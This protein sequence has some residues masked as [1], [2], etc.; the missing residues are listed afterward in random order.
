[1]SF[2]SDSSLISRDSSLSS[3]VAGQE[4]EPF[5][6]GEVSLGL[7]GSSSN[8]DSRAIVL[9]GVRMK[10]LGS[11]REERLAIRCLQQREGGW[12]SHNGESGLRISAQMLP[13]S[14]NLRR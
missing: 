4:L 10:R 2:K 14:D 6:N 11:L 5:S 9:N 1:M 12:S 8:G 7:A 13:V 3:A